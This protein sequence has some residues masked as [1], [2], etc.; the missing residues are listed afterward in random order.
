MSKD[1]DYKQFKAERSGNVS[2]ILQNA[3]TRFYK[4]WYCN[5]TM[6]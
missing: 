3:H 4:V 6:I 2:K 1:F 5:K